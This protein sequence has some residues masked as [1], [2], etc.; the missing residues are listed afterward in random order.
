MNQKCIWC[1]N[2]SNKL[3][4]LIASEIITSQQSNQK[5]FLDDVKKAEVIVCESCLPEVFIA[6]KRSDSKVVQRIS[7]AA[8]WYMDSF[9]LRINYL[10]L[11]L[12]ALFV[13]L[14]IV[15]LDLIFSA[16]LKINIP[17]F[18]QIA[19]GL[20]ILIG[21]YSIFLIV[22]PVLFLAMAICL[23]GI[24]ESDA[25][26]LKEKLK[27]PSF[28]RKVKVVI[29][30]LCL[31]FFFFMVTM[32]ISLGLLLTPYIT[33]NLENTYLIISFD[34]YPPFIE[35]S[36]DSIVLYRLEYI[37]LFI[38]SFLIAAHTILSKRKRNELRKELLTKLNIC[39]V[40]EVK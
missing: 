33:G 12:L 17:I 1:R 26:A 15:I 8:N 23:A 34:L 27:K 35:V 37:H 30:I 9:F 13:I 3:Y 18:E 22:F 38:F 4:K 32:T 19:I 14:P 20:T 2:E 39:G 16:I 10:F 7:H 11:K 25:L 24:Y 28:P 6:I 36:V 40:Y 5:S 21:Y 29:S 31:L